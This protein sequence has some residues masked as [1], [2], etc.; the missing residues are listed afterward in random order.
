MSL[1]WPGWT[2]LRVDVKQPTIAATLDAATLTPQAMRLLLH[3]NLARSVEPTARAPSAADAP[4]HA[5]AEEATPAEAAAD[6]AAVTDAAAA[7]DAIMAALPRQLSLTPAAVE[8]AGAT[9]TLSV[10]SVA[11]LDVVLAPG[12][13]LLPSFM[14]D[15]LGGR[16]AVTLAVVAAA[17]AARAGALHAAAGDWTRSPPPPPTHHDPASPALA[18]RPLAPIALRA[19]TEHGGVAATGWWTTT[20]L[21]WREPATAALDFT[22]ALVEGVIGHIHPLLAGAVKL[23]E[24][25][26]VRV[27]LE[28]SRLRPWRLRHKTHRA[29]AA[30]RPPMRATA[31]AADARRSV[32][33]FSDETVS[34]L[35]TATG[36]LSGTSFAVKEM[37]P[38]AGHVS[39]FGVREW[40]EAHASVATADAPAVAA[41][42]AAGARLTG[43]TVMDQLA[44]SLA[45]DSGESVPVNPAAPGRL[46]GGSSSGSAAAVAAADVTFALGSDTAGSVRVPASYCGVWGFRPTHGRLSL[47]GS[48]ALAPSFDTVGWFAR[49]GEVLERLGR[50]LLGGTPAA[51]V[52]RTA[53]APITLTRWLVAADAF[54]AARPDVAA[55]L[56]AAVAP[57]KDGI[58]ALL[59]PPTEVSAFGAAGA[60]A[61]RDAFRFAQASEIAA[62]IAPW[63]AAA[64][65]VLKPDIAERVRWAATEVSGAAASAAA[66]TRREFS[67]RLDALLATDGA[68]FLPTAPTPAPTPE[69]AEAARAGVLELTCV[70]GLARLPQLTLPVM[71]SVDGAPVGLSVIG[72]RGSDEALLEL[73]RKLGGVFGV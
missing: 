73:G 46:T 71:A 62:S 14:A 61:A 52:A 2:R 41:L 25:D 16:V 40:R 44:Y 28:P 33:A 50:V 54:D 69:E 12:S 58:Q 36:P 47:E 38:V 37:F 53:G 17:I 21:A 45:G 72:P 6:V 57:V 34:A 22:S 48:P 29:L 26:V 13:V 63:V 66:A 55:A 42:R 15:V 68:L 19:E 7:G 51:G 70:A 8:L 30:R 4:D 9:L 60:A 31:T 24:E 32:G 59:S 23:E 3:L 49:D 5:D 10:G 67:N 65:P 27:R 35:P 39:R 18:G 56:Y 11:S 43:R 20:G 1:A 64:R